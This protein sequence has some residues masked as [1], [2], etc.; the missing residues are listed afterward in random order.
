MCV[1]LIVSEWTNANR[2]LSRHFACQ[3]VTEFL[4]LSTIRCLAECVWI[5]TKSVLSCPGAENGNDRLWSSSSSSS[6]YLFLCCKNL[7]MFVYF[8]SLLDLELISWHN[9][10]RIVIQIGVSSFSHVQTDFLVARLYPSMYL[11]CIFVSS[12]SLVSLVRAWTHRSSGWRVF[13]R[14]CKSVCVCQQWLSAP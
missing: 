1:H 9:H 8:F 3:R 11:W 2:H 14:W 4:Y 5:R 13:W 6:Y 7:S 12:I 10:A